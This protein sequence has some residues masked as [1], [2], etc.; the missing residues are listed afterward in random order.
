M[1]S[2]YFYSLIPS[3]VFT[4]QPRLRMMH[5]PASKW[6]LVSKKQHHLSARTVLLFTRNS[7]LSTACAIKVARVYWLTFAFDCKTTN[8]TSVPEAKLQIWYWLMRFEK[9]HESC[10]SVLSRFFCI[11]L[12][13]RDLSWK[14]YEY[15]HT[16][17]HIDEKA[18]QTKTLSDK[19]LPYT[20]I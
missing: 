19:S 1:I 6:P 9:A 7:P 13:C 17:D 5:T 14:S 18:A 15:T 10:R 12:Y 4:F 11:S 20:L 16:T 2:F 3:S 8:Y